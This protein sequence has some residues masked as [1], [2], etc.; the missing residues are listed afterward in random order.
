VR[1]E[2]GV[3]TTTQATGVLTV[4]AEGDSL[5]GKLVPDRVQG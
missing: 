2:N 4:A 1:V 5:I 3:A